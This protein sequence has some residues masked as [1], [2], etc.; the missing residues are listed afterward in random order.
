MFAG[1]FSILNHS[2]E[3]DVDPQVLEKLKI[4]GGL[5][6]AAIT[7]LVL[8]SLWFLH[9]RKA[10]W[11]EVTESDLPVKKPRGP[12]WALPILISLGF[13][14]A[15][16]SQFPSIPFW[17]SDNTYRLAHAVILISF[18]GAVGG[19]IRIPLMFRYLGLVLVLSLVY[20]MLTE[21]YQENTAIFAHRTE[22]FGYACVAALGGAALIVKID[23]TSN[24]TWGWVDAGCWILFFGL[25]MPIW[26]WNGYATGS[27]VVPGVLAVLGS[28]AIVA[29]ICKPIRLSSGAITSLV[30]VAVVLLIGASVHSGVRSLPAF[31]LIIVGLGLQ[32]IPINTK[33]SIRHAF[34]RVTFTVLA[35]SAAGWLAY[36]EH[37]LIEGASDSYY[38]DDPYA[39]YAE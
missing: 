7:F 35:M 31:A 2:W 28:A 27:N 33:W 15:T 22:Y 32:G 24:E 25:S 37:K 29:L 1:M 39:D 30:G 14:G 12:R 20:W 23:E 5:V 18:V 26:F 13:L 36:H 9:T 6:P 3:V 19:V 38:E 16:Y 17:P 21:G 4:W 10:I 34:V 11:K 8:L